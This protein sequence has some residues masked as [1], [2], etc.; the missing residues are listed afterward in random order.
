[1]RP[2]QFIIP[3]FFMV[4]LMAYG[5]K[6]VVTTVRTH[7]FKFLVVFVLLAT[8][9]SMNSEASESSIFTELANSVITLLIYVFTLVYFK[10]A[11]TKEKKIVLFASI[12]ILGLSIWYDTFIGLDIVGEGNIRKGGFA[13]NPNKGASAIKFLGF[14][15]LLLLTK[16]KDR[17]AILVLIT[18]TIFIT[19]SKSG[20]LSLII[21]TVMLMINKWER[22]FNVRGENVFLAG[23][24][25]AAAL[26]ISIVLLTNLANFVQSKVPAFTQGDAAQRINQI[27]GKSEQAAV[28]TKRYSEFNGRMRIAEIYYNK[29][30]DNPFGYGTGYS[31]DGLVNRLDTHN[32]YLKVA[33]DYSF[34]GL[35]IL[36]AYLFYLIKRSIDFNNYHYFIFAFLLLFECFISH[37]LFVER[38][39]IIVLAFMDSNLFFRKTED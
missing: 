39:V 17:V 5:I 25:I 33:V 21:F 10:N 29:F 23:F 19:F 27:L 14:A 3:L 1:L 20:L 22:P 38:A 30:M 26:A 37:D 34:V 36:L 15:L 8:V 28:S 35:L 16:T 12:T 4:S 24:K 32:Y 2:S 18:A 13:E 6:E 11:S 9:F 31:N 7:S